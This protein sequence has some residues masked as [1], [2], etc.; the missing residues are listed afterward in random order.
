MDR[1]KDYAYPAAAAGS[2]LLIAYVLAE[3]LEPDQPLVRQIGEHPRV[4]AQSTVPLDTAYGN[5]YSLGNP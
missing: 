1:L 3:P 4:Y 5:A 2:L